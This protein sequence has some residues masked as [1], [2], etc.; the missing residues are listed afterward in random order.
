MYILPFSLFCFVCIILYFIASCV[1]PGLHISECP[2]LLVH[3]II[4]FSHN[5]KDLAIMVN[6]RRIVFQ[7]GKR[8][9]N[10]Y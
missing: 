3:R 2:I 9:N 10:N 5:S 8:S 4:D 7:H 1:M 6:K